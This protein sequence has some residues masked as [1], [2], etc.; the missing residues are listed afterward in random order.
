MVN[1]KNLNARKTGDETEP[2]QQQQ[3]LTWSGSGCDKVCRSVLVVVVMDYSGDGLHQHRH[4][5]HHHHHFFSITTHIKAVVVMVSKLRRTSLKRG[6]MIAA[7]AVTTVD[8][9]KH[10]E[11]LSVCKCWTRRTPKK[12]RL[13]VRWAA[14]RLKASKDKYS[15][16]RQW[17]LLTNLLSPPP[18]LGPQ[19][20]GSRRFA[21]L[22][23]KFLS[24]GVR[25]LVCLL[26]VQRQSC[27]PWPAT[28][29]ALQT[30]ERSLAIIWDNR[31]MTDWL[32]DWMMA[33]LDFKA[34]W[35]V[36]DR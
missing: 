36:G 32:N 24:S 14:K 25:W 7:A 35:L 8:E 13:T 3:Q 18:P 5:H 28:T 27:C 9:R 30:D 10:R 16:Q 17:W 23:W 2:K 12:L 29:A 31:K 20:V 6:E 22:Y 26:L 4:H 11:T 15:N 19:S 33:I 1:Q 21:V 34:C